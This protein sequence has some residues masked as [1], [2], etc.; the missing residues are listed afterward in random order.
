MA[1]S[2]VIL[3]G[4]CSSRMG[5][6]KTELTVNEL[7]LLD[8]AK[9][10]LQ[11]TGANPI[12][13]SRNTFDMGTLP[14]IYPHHGPL[15][16][17]HSAAMEAKRAEGLLVIAVDMPLISVN[18][19]TVLVATGQLHNRPVHYQGASLPCYIPLSD[20]IKLKLEHILTSKQN[21]TLENF[22]YHEKT[23]VLQ[24]R[25]KK[26]FININTPEQWQEFHPYLKQ[27]LK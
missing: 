15:S 10:R 16:G 14:D 8:Y 5:Q 25:D 13:I 3:A 22:L 19:L 20:S 26:E 6:D 4:G 21:K 11:S 17:V 18:S 9:A 1:F 7:S 12:L 23:L 2:G 24:P 27:Q